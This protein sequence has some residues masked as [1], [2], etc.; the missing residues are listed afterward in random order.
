VS[1]YVINNFDSGP[2]VAISSPMRGSL[3]YLLLASPL[4]AQSGRPVP[5]QAPVDAL[6]QSYQSA[7]SNGR[8]DE[9]AA[10][11]DQARALLS[12]IPVDDPQF[13][14]WAQRVSQLYD[15]GGFTLKA[16]DILE[17][18]LARAGGLGDSSP[19]RIAL[20]DALAR[21]WEQDRNLLKSVSYLEQAV[22]AA[23]AQPPRTAQAPA[24]ASR[25][26]GVTGS[27]VTA[28]TANYADLYQRLFRLYRQLGR[29]QDAAAILT[30]VAARVKNSDQLMASLYQQNGQ[31][32]EAA[33]IYKRQAA[34]AADPQQAAVALQS[35]ASLYQG[36]QRYGDAVAAFEQAIGK[37]EVSG[38]PAASSG[39]RQNLAN[40]FQQAGQIQAADA[41]YQELMAGQTDQQLGIVAS[42]ANFLEQTNRVDQAEK[43]LNDYQASHASAEPSEQ[44][45][46]MLALAYVERLSRKPELAEE[47]Q[48]RAFPNQPQPADVGAADPM[49]RATEALD[50]G[51]LDE[52]FN[53]TLQ[54]LDSADG[55]PDREREYWMAPRLASPQAPSKGDEIYR[56]ALA[57]AENWSAAKVWPLLNIIQ[58]YAQS[59]AGQRRWGDFEQ[60]SER[61]RATLTA[62]RGTGTGWLEDAMRLR[63]ATGDA[64]AAS[65]ELVTLEESLSG[66]TSEPYLRAIETLANAMEAAGDRAG[67]LPRRRSV[68]TI[69]DLVYSG[70]NETRRA[71]VRIDAA[72]ACARAE[73][74]DEAETLSKEA[75]AISQH[76]QPPQPNMFAGQLQQIL[77]MRQAAL[78]V[79][80]SKQ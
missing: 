22:A 11:R 24:P 36:A 38:G 57:L 45:A 29:P 4:L 76:M 32:D 31:I 49:R 74:F 54:A 80:A 42:Y 6:V 23:E 56:H 72:I 79:S 28:V 1:S 21:S 39:M 63:T 70:S 13:A 51:K 3:P 46:L 20:L 25:W 5:Q 69:A 50:A 68:V 30:R 37:T 52:A 33:A 44:Q 10:K 35:L 53:L 60:A 71:V 7:Y 18:A 19:A 17:Q 59:L 43:L 66:A 58:S 2:L 34:E 41:V 12:Q 16:R 15:G 78:A 55:A 73:Q 67:A 40:M 47:Y 48:R 65:H 27:R 8:Y 9:A 61:Y 14:N 75:V 77:Q 64:L 62:A 26:F